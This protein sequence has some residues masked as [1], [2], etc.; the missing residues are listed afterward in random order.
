MIQDF[1][2]KVGLYTPSPP[3]VSSEPASTIASSSTS[4][5]PRPEKP[6]GSSGNVQKM[7]DASVYSSPVSRAEHLTFMAGFKSSLDTIMNNKKSST[8]SGSPTKKA[9]R[10]NSPRKTAAPVL[11]SPISPCKVSAT[12]PAII[13][14]TLSND[15]TST[16]AFFKLLKRKKMLK[17]IYTQNIDGF[18]FFRASNSLKETESSERSDLSMVPTE[19]NTPSVPLG[20]FSPFAYHSPVATPTRPKSTNKSAASHPSLTPASTRPKSSS[21]RPTYEGDV[22]QLHGSLQFVRCTV[23]SYVAAWTPEHTDALG[24]GDCME[25][26]DCTYRGTRCANI[27]RFS[28]R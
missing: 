7:F 15:I 12:L 5:S 13:K 27:H 16:H 19:V 17:R 6:R 4:T 26:P 20:L 3:S 22:V 1:R 24:A 25:C 8:L 14:E 10:N 28:C 9:L 2:S 23:C 21:K 18:E 11:H